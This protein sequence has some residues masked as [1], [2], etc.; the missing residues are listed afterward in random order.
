MHLIFDLPF[1]YDLAPFVFGRGVHLERG[2]GWL[3][4][5]FFLHIRRLNVRATTFDIVCSLATA[6]LLAITIP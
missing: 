4:F 5:F 1:V 6:C 2:V 3:E